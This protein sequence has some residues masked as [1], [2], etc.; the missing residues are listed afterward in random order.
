MGPGG[1]IFTVTETFI[2]VYMAMFSPQIEETI[3]IRTPA[4]IRRSCMETKA[5]RYWVMPL[6]GKWSLPYPATEKIEPDRQSPLA[7]GAI[8]VKFW[9]IR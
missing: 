9:N 2:L 7:L 4:I 8:N 3:N 5:R 6:N 1:P